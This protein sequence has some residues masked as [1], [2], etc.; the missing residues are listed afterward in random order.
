MKRTTAWLLGFA[1]AMTSVAVTAQD[2]PTEDDYYKLEAL[3]IP[4]EAYL[5]AGGLEIMPD[6][7]LAASSRRGE[8]WMFDDPMAED[9]ESVTA[10]RYAHGLHEVLGLAQREGWLYCIQRGELTRMKDEDDDGRADLF[11]TVS[12]GW[13]IN[14]D[15]HEYAFGS[16]FDKNGHL[17]TVLCLTGS[18][19]SNVK[20]RGWCLRLT[21]DGKTI[22]T[23]SGI[24]SPGGIGFNAEGDVFY[25]DNQGPWNGTC[26]LKWLKPG[27]FQGHPAGNR[28]YEFAPEMPKPQDPQSG[29]RFHIEADKIPQYVPAA[30]LFP[31]NKMGK[32]AS[33][34]E[35]DTTGGKFGPFAGQVFVGDQSHST[36]MRCYLEKVAGNYQGACFMFRQGIGSGTLPLLMHK[37]GAMFVG[38]TNRGWGS[39]G[40][41]PYSLERLTWTGEVPFEVHEMRAKPDGFELTFTLPVDAETAGDIAS[42]K[43]TTYTYIFQSAY[44]SPEVDHTAPKITNVVVADD[45]KSARLYVDKLQRGHIHE[46][47]MPG[48]RSKDGLPLL[49]NVGYYTLNNIPEE[50]KISKAGEPY[51]VTIAP[52]TASSPDAK[53]K[54]EVRFRPAGNSEY[55]SV[56]VERGDDGLYC[57]IPA[58]VTDAPFEYY[59]KFSEQG[60]QPTTRPSSG[61]DSPFQV[62][63]DAEAP[64]GVDELTAR[65]VSDIAVE[66]AW[67]A[68]TDDRGVAG[69]SLFRGNAEGFDCTQATQI[70]RTSGPELHWTDPEPPAGLTAWYA[71]RASDV[72]GRKGP[73]RYLSVDVPRNAAP[74]NL[75]KLTAI[76]A[77]KKAFLR[78]TGEMDPDVTA[79]EI[80]RGDGE[81]GE[82]AKIETVTDLKRGR[83]VDEN[84]KADGTYRYAVRVVDR[85]KLASDLTEPQIVRSGLYLRRI[86][87]GGEEFI[88]ADGIPWE[89]DRDRQPGSGIWSTKSAV[90]DA[91]D[92]GPVYQSERWSNLAVKYR[93]EVEP[94]QYEVSLLLAEI[95]PQFA[96]E[97]KR[98]FNISINGEQ[99]H[100][101]FDIFTKVGAQAACEVTLPAEPV[102]GAIEIELR[103]VSGGPALKGIQIRGLK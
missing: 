90:A 14:G 78:W 23:C 8:I 41:K 74:R 17:W 19:S 82:L 55:Q 63:I 76:S 96:K 44:G 64:S 103:K 83:F 52:F 49:H 85:G 12:D 33:G 79:V 16:K 93:L 100:K 36:I 68:A 21:D 57:V 5:E 32:S 60:R 62:Q 99:R 10:Q 34:V 47:H 29:S 91:D 25:T 81:E 87:C 7:R 66:L 59:V 35:P 86:N 31:Y 56:P 89:A 39:R 15:Y 24:R 69:Y 65:E 3:P 28:W 54:A 20:F 53:W 26:A 51:E 46:L 50:P 77:G 70:A 22:P 27:S 101:A 42:Y 61:A 40:G 98:T 95:N 1:L 37:D 67:Q 94:G 13:E 38:G 18:F 30:I 92:L 80:L 71:V 43:M 102:D 88:G 9:V 58:A 72:A 75:L 2:N 45:G 97:G 11:E 48:I 73:P 4:A 6:G 84:L